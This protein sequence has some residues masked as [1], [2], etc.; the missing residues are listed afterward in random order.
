MTTYGSSQGWIGVDLDGTLAEYYGPA[1]GI[2][3]AVP[4]MVERIKQH[5][6]DG[7]RVKIFTA[8]ATGSQKEVR[9]VSDW[10]LEVFGER[11]EVTCQKDYGMILFYDDRA[12]QVITNSGEIVGEEVRRL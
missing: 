6:A 11:L 8:R 9:E 1:P 5:L 7:E 2:G 3:P 10:S 4:A 12:R